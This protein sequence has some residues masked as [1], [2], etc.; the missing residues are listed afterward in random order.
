MRVLYLSWNVWLHLFLGIGYENF[1]LFFFSSWSRTFCERSY[2]LVSALIFE[3]MLWFN[4]AMRC[5]PERSW[6]QYFLTNFV[7]F[8]HSAVFHIQYRVW[9]K[10]FKQ[11]IFSEYLFFRHLHKPKSNTVKNSFLHA[12]G[13]CLLKPK[14]FPGGY[15]CLPLFSLQYMKW[16]AIQ[17][18]QILIF[19]ACLCI[20][21][22]TFSEFSGFLLACPKLLAS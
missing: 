7:L 4:F 21:L 14:G 5:Y 1:T 17:S 15:A 20:H 19:V 22:S 10:I 12:F 8:H 16:Q 13:F 2:C 3:V 9:W 6:I 11:K 18:A